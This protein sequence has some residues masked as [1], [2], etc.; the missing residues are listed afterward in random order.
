MQTLES[1]K[2]LHQRELFCYQLRL[3]FIHVFSSKAE[4]RYYI[5]LIIHKHICL[6]KLFEGEIGITW[7]DG[8]DR[9]K[10]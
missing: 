5:S 4:S 6:L 8:P 7:P 9:G 10:R 1:E 2:K 3:S